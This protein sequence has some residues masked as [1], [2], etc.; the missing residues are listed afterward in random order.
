MR[1]MEPGLFQPTQNN[2]PVSGEAAGVHRVRAGDGPAIVSTH[3]PGTA[4]GP[5]EGTSNRADAGRG[6]VESQ[7]V[8]GLLGDCGR[9]RLF[10]ARPRCANLDVHDRP[11]PR[12]RRPPHDRSS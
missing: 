9:R 2:R 5:M 1:G 3:H 4:G 8:R 11:P 7:G 12:D 6:H 10:V